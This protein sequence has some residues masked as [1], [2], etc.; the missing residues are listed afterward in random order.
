VLPLFQQYQEDVLL[1][2]SAPQSR[3]TPSTLFAHDEWAIFVVGKR[4]SP[5][6][7]EVFSHALAICHE[8]LIYLTGVLV[9]SLVF[10]HV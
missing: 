4:N 10:C 6:L 7:C 2:W 3:G 8:Y 9:L 1:R 5:Q